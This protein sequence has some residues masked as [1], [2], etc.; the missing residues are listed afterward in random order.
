[1]GTRVVEGEIERGNVRVGI[2]AAGQPYVKLSGETVPLEES[3]KIVRDGTHEG[4]PIH[5]ALHVDTV[6]PPGREA[7]RVIYDGELSAPDRSV[8]GLHYLKCWVPLPETG[9]KFEVAEDGFQSARHAAVVFWIRRSILIGLLLAGVA[10]IFR[11]LK[12]FG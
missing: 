11:L 6:G 1:M 3:G 12:P 2:D 7:L 9:R 8:A 10:M 4:H 5:V